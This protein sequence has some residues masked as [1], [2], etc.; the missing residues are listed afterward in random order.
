MVGYVVEEVARRSAPLHD[1]TLPS[2]NLR[3][4]VLMVMTVMVMMV[5]VAVDMNRPRGEE[6][7]LRL[8]SR[9]GRVAAPQTLQHQATCRLS[10]KSNS[11]VTQQ[12]PYS[13][14]PT[15]EPKYSSRERKKGRRTC[16]DDPS[17]INVVRKRPDPA[18]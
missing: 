16:L 10:A 6:V 14:T 13:K 2:H 15:V 4:C 1:A 12:N 3:K 5:V 18:S 17:T 8:E 9:L 11:V 7:M